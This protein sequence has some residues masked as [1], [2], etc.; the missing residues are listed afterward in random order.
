M[1][2]LDVEPWREAKLAEAGILFDSLKQDQDAVHVIHRLR[3][4][5]GLDTYYSSQEQMS[6]TER[7]GVETLDTAEMTASGQ[8]PAQ[9][10]AT[11]ATDAAAL[12]AYATDDGIELTTIHRSKGREWPRVVL[13]GVDQGQLPHARSIAGDPDGAGQEDERRLAYVAMTRARNTLEIVYSSA[14]PSTFLSEAGLLATDL[15]DSDQP[16]PPGQGALG[17]APA[18]GAILAVA[19]M[20][21]QLAAA[22]EISRLDPRDREGQRGPF[23]RDGLG[24]QPATRK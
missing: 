7:I 8:T 2:G 5:G 13:F 14:T 10:A 3:T 16:K 21:D 15:G 23:R 6:E 12:Q 1:S 17:V 22:A 11:I 20:S 9:C 24:L 4:E 19:A 18:V